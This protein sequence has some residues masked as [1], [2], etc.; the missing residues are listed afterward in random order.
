M[1]ARHQRGDRVLPVTAEIIASTP[2]ERIGPEEKDEGQE[3]EAGPDEREQAKYDSGNSAQ[4]QQ[5]P[6]F[7]SSC[8]M[9]VPR[10]RSRR[11]SLG[12]V[13]RRKSSAPVHL[14]H[15]REAGDAVN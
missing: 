1:I 14:V 2:D 12:T 6:V 9:V 10:P 7:D 8:T 3:G 5:P 15:A 13:V 4:Q 11:S